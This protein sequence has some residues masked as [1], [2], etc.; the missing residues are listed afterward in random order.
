[1]DGW[2]QTL[3][4]CQSSVTRKFLTS[5]PGMAKTRGHHVKIKNQTARGAQ[6]TLWLVEVN[7][8]IRSMFVHPLLKA[9]SQT[10]AFMDLVEGFVSTVA[11]VTW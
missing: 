7:D 4:A 5:L 1:M 11:K 10:P 6:N 8:Q 9:P 3:L 2:P